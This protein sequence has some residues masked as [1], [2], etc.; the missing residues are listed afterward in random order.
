MPTKDPVKKAAQRKRW[1]EKNAAY[2]KEWREA[3]PEKNAEYVRSAQARAVEALA[4]DVSDARHGTT[5]GYAYGCRCDR[6]KEARRK[7][8]TTKTRADRAMRHSIEQ[9][10][11]DMASIV[12][13]FREEA[14][15]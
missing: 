8:A 11:A 6:C 12:H 9:E 15:A 13:F 14:D 7:Y 10:A 3:H 5:T 2:L 1:R 4:N